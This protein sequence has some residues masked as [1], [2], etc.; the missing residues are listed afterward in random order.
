MTKYSLIIRWSDEDQCYIAWIPE[1]GI[2]TKT[3][4]ATYEEAARA[5][6]EVIELLGEHDGE[7]P[8]PE[9]WLYKDVE[10]DAQLGR[11][12]FPTNPAYRDPVR[13]SSPKKAK[14]VTA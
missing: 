7:L 2:G 3:H 14:H 8:L 9:P 5:G 13:A 10:S 6:Q 4:G 1:F 12:L 11:H